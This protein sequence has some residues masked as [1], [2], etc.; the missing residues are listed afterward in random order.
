MGRPTSTVQKSLLMSHREEFLLLRRR[1]PLVL[2]KHSIPSIMKYAFLYLQWLKVGVTII[3]R[4]SQDEGS[5]RIV[6][7]FENGRWKRNS[8]N[9]SQGQQQE[10]RQQRREQQQQQQGQHGQQQRPKQLRQLQEQQL[11]RWL[12][13][14]LQHTRIHERERNKTYGSCSSQRSTGTSR[15]SWA[16]MRPNLYKKSK[17]GIGTSKVNCNQFENLRKMSEASRK[18]NER[19]TNKELH[20]VNKSALG[21]IVVAN[22]EAEKLTNHSASQAISSSRPSH[23][24]VDAL[25]FT[26]HDNPNKFKIQGKHFRKINFDSSHFERV[27]DIYFKNIANGQKRVSSAPHTMASGIK[28]ENAK[29]DSSSH[30]RIKD[31]MWSHYISTSANLSPKDLV[32]KGSTSNCLSPLFNCSFQVHDL[33]STPDFKKELSIDPESSPLQAVLKMDLFSSPTK[34]GYDIPCSPVYEIQESGD[35]SSV[36]PLSPWNTKSFIPHS[37]SLFSAKTA[38]FTERRLANTQKLPGSFCP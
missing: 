4:D 18:L 20:D 25:H 31:P 6:H 14:T 29:S 17:H 23:D 35:G 34:I 21:H 24:Q 32:K 30:N 11:R 5:R 16:Q 1:Q 22:H 38:E 33:P 19:K 37:P 12:W 8:F 28:Y 7:V 15:P 26:I 13:S 9:Q 3:R 36:V 2:G 27:H 10:K